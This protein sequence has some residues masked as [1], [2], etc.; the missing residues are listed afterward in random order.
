MFVLAKSDSLPDPRRAKKHSVL[1]LLSLG[2]PGLCHECQR[3]SWNVSQWEDTRLREPHAWRKILRCWNSTSP[4]PNC[5]LSVDRSSLLD[6]AAR[7]PFDMHSRHRLPQAQGK[8]SSILGAV[9]GFPEASSIPVTHW[10]GR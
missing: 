6:L 1:L 2:L 9:T 7:A 8:C 3:P 10:T 4:S 5:F